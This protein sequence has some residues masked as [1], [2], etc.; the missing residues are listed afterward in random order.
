M[1]ASPNPALQQALALANQ[2][3]QRQDVAGA[4]RA[5]ASLSMSGLSGHPEVLN[6]LGIIR[7]AQ[8]RFA[9]AVQH[10]S[11]AIAAVPREPVLAYNLGR[12]FARQGQANEAL[13]AFRAAIK[14]KPDFV[15]ALFDHA[16]L[17]H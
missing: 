13:K 6:L 9:E 15:E 1:A 7:T 5:L 14:L 2:C 10:L 8:G 16:H 4:E 12:A 11:Q 17:L 3:L